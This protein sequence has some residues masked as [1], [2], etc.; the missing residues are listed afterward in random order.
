MRTFI[1]PSA[2][3]TEAIVARSVPPAQPDSP[4]AAR[5]IR[6]DRAA[7][8]GCETG[9]ETSTV[10]PA[11]GSN[12]AHTSTSPCAGMFTHQRPPLFQSEIGPATKRPCPALQ[13][14]MLLPA[15]GFG[16]RDVIEQEGVAAHRL[17]GRVLERDPE[18]QGAVVLTQ[19]GEPGRDAGQTTFLLGALWRRLARRGGFESSTKRRQDQCDTQ[20]GSK[21]H[22][23]P[24]D[25]HLVPTTLTEREDPPA[26]SAS[27][28]RTSNRT[29]PIQRSGHPLGRGRPPR[30]SR[31]CRQPPTRL[32][33]DVGVNPVEKGADRQSSA[34]LI[35]VHPKTFTSRPSCILR[36]D[37]LTIL[38]PRG[39]QTDIPGFAVAKSCRA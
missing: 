9:S 28:A 24:S 39:G 37:S 3:V 27:S 26:S 18:V 13:R 4:R 17:V 11:I 25:G 5:R 35:V 32:A 15:L 8:N 20:G 22:E 21:S 36:F 16:E 2:R 7:S 23:T 14:K 6:V 19:I 10:D 34:S 33:C 12:S 38:R 29:P 1:C 31:Q 30:R